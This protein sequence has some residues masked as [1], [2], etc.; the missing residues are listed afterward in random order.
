MAMNLA[1]VNVGRRSPFQIDYAGSLF[2]LITLVYVSLSFNILVEIGISS[3]SRMD[4]KNH[5]LNRLSLSKRRE[6]DFPHYH[7]FVI[8]EEELVFLNQTI[9][10]ISKNFNE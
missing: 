2:L 3:S 1:R 5:E 6:S 8:S 4:L 7:H 9:S 10:A